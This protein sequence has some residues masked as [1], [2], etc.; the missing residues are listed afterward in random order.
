MQMIPLTHHIDKL[1]DFLIQKIK[2]ADSVVE[3]IKVNNVKVGS[4]EKEVID[5]IKKEFFY[6]K[7]ECL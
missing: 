7:E 4:P 6:G 1:D 3:M 5:I 2:I